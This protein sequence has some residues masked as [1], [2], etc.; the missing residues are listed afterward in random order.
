MTSSRTIQLCV[1]I[2][3]TAFDI[4]LAET[5]SNKE[6]SGGETTVFQ[7]GQNAYSL[8]LANIS[9][10]DRRAHVVGNSF[11][12]KN[13]VVAP[14]SPEA[15]D[16]LGP[17]FNA[18]SCSACHLRDGRGKPPSEEQSSDSLLFRISILG[19]SHNSQTIPDP[20][21]GTQI[22]T[23]AIPGLL[24]EGRVE[25]RYTEREEAKNET[26][27]FLRTP[28]YRFIPSQDYLDHSRKLMLSPR[29]APP[30]FGLGLLEAIS[31][32]TLREFE[33]PD[34]KNQDGISGRLNFIPHPNLKHPQIGRFGWKANQIDL[35]HQITAAFRH[36]LGITSSIH[37]T[38]SLSPNQ[39]DRMSKI[40]NGGNPEL[41][42]RILQRV[43]RY[44]QTLAPPA[45]RM[46]TDSKVLRG[47][48]LFTK[49]RCHLCHIPK[50]E[51]GRHPDIQELSFQ[52]IRPFTDLLLHDM[53]EGLADGR[54]DFAASGSEWRTP[55]L[56]GIGLTRTV[57]GNDFYLHDGRARSL[58]EAILWHGGEAA[59]SRDTFNEFSEEEKRALIQ[60][61]ES[62]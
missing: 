49:A 13:W 8:P 18:S 60:F 58:T 45:R 26:G 30:V 9:R 36:D 59:Q 16:G 29:L 10:M 22:A 21:L 44:Q 25:V 47:E 53:G 3:T 19:D 46:W 61:L 7:E 20:I 43:L 17:L 35:L 42:D 37:P 39:L 32:A 57:N 6:L 34:D 24:E 48:Q 12:N 55:P 15:R 41:S 52:T 1:I 40:P 51:T 33:D 23:H 62:L 14:S 31:E 38:E 5:N 50:L 28:S 4:A 11:F 2:L 27:Y 56:W 54:P